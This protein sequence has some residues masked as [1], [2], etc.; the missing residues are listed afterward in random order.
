MAKTLKST[1]SGVWLMQTIKM[2]VPVPCTIEYTVRH[3]GGGNNDLRV[4]FGSFWN[5]IWAKVHDFE[6]E[7]GKSASRS[8]DVNNDDTGSADAKQDVRWRLSRAILTKEIDWELTYTVTRIK[9]GTDA[10]NECAA[11][12][13]NDKE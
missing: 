7:P 9:G 11:T 12:V 1:L 10:T 2:T 5:L 8:P 6:L 3:K 4:R 13:T